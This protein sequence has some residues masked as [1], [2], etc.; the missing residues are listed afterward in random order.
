MHISYVIELYVSEIF[1]ANFPELAIIFQK[2]NILG[3]KLGKF[4]TMDS[5]G[6]TNDT[7][8]NDQLFW[9]GYGWNLSPER[10]PGVNLFFDEKT[11]NFGE[12]TFKKNRL[13]SHMLIPSTNN[14]NNKNA[15]TVVR[16]SVD[17]KSSAP[18]AK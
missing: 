2:L 12:S 4:S 1:S 8:F 10:F 17:G 11:S 16:R 3:L 5:F 14:L 13:P 6:K 18:P 15:L 7:P 9:L